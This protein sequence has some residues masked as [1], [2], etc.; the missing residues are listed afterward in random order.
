MSRSSVFT[1]LVVPPLQQ[2]T[3]RPGGKMLTKQLTGRIRETYWLVLPQPKSFYTNNLVVYLT[4]V[5]TDREN[6]NL[7]NEHFDLLVKQGDILGSATSYEGRYFSANPDTVSRYQIV[8]KLG[9]G[10]FG[11]V[12]RAKDLIQGKDV[13]VK[14]L[15]SKSAYFRQGML[16]VSVLSMV[17]RSR[18]RPPLVTA[19]PAGTHH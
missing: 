6:S 14:I 17:W 4:D 8:E 15:K 3:H 10:M 9:N 5:T 12:F 13:A 7:D 16:E 18:A 19:A 1:P 2:S 11:H